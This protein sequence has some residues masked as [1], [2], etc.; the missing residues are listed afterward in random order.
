VSV[1]DAD[2]DTDDEQALFGE[3]GMPA[4]REGWHRSTLRALFPTRPSQAEAAT[5]LLSQDWTGP[6]RAGACSPWPTRTGC[7]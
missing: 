1:E 4:P 5:L 7:A 2:A 6:A 3:P